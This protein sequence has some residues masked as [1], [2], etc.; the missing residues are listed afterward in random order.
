[1]D[2]IDLAAD[3]LRNK[4]DCSGLVA[5]AG[6]CFGARN[7]Y[8]SLTE[9]TSIDAGVAFYPTPRLHEVFDPAAAA[10]IEKPMMFV[11]GGQDPYISR[12]EKK[13]MRDAS[14]TVIRMIPGEDEPHVEFSDGNKNL[15]T[16]AYTAN[17][18]GFNRRGSDYSDP[19]ASEHVLSSAVEFLHAALNAQR[20]RFEIPR[21]ASTE[22]PQSARY[23]PEHK[24]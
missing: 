24:V 15:I 23:L 16:L 9:G 19:G 3:Y 11:Y 21:I 18:H 20:P 10:A 13:S 22:M 7:A 14:G 8:L 6:F 4:S 1:M 5:A 12:E 2:T 17:D